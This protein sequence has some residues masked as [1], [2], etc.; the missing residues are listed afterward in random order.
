MTQQQRMILALVLSFIFF[1]GYDFLM[2]KPQRVAVDQNHTSSIAAQTQSTTAPISSTTAAPQQ[3]THTPQVAAPVVSSQQ[4]N[5]ITTVTSKDF[6]LTIDEL[7][8]V[9]RY[10]VLI[11]RFKSEDGSYPNLISDKSDLKPLEIRFKD[12]NLNSEAFSKTYSSD[13]R[14]VIVDG[15]SQTVTLTQKLSTTEVTKKITFN[16]DGTYN[17]TVSLSSPSDYFISPG[18]RPDV[19]SDM[20]TFKGVLIQKADGTTDT[21][22]DGDAEGN[23]V[24]MGASILASS[25][26]YYTTALYSFDERFNIFLSKDSEDDPLAFIKGSQNLTVN[27]YIGPKEYDKLNA[28]DPQMTNIIE[29]GFFTFLAKPVFLF[30]K[31]IHSIL[32][33][34]GWSIV[35]ITLLIRLI[36]Y[37]LTYKGMVSMNRLKE[38]SPKIK[39]IQKQYKGEPQKMNA[40]MMELYKKHNAN[41]MGGCLPMVMQ[42]PVFFAIYRV[43]LNSIELKHAEW[44]GWYHDLSV[45]DPY[46]VLPVLMGASM[47][48][49]QRITPT[50]FTDPMQEKIMKFLPL[51][52]T[53]F[54]VTFPAG[55]TLYWFTNNL[56]SVAQQ[57]Y[58]NSIFA[59]EK[60]RKASA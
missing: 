39:E 37:P 41:P 52:F 60:A 42:I 11:E 56:F 9:S 40:K 25:D 14:D 49:Q 29:Y 47:F 32:G 43:L 34:W 21:I 3:Q 59:K 2:P 5:T 48:W 30:L 10:E 6:K 4:S 50:N 35:A 31:Y 13:V 27:G 22:A 51:I 19:A 55:L 53:F 54:F 16:P 44:I 1:I 33:N 57:Y 18:F 15:T 17:I 26:K 58:V 23:E 38:L 24:F 36:L 8:R 7:G 12:A 46:Y 20:Y 45:M 28:I